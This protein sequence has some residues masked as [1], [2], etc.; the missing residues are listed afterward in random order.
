M[1]SSTHAVFLARSESSLIPKALNVPKARVQRATRTHK[2]ACN[3]EFAS[4]FVCSLLVG[5]ALLTAAAAALPPLLT[6]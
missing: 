2:R 5:N 4:L 3:V 1:S 6:P